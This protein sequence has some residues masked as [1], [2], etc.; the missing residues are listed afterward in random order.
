MKKSYQRAM[1]GVL[2]VVVVLLLHGLFT[3]IAMLK[4]LICNYSPIVNMLYFL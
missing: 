4:I 3:L 2:V 1:S